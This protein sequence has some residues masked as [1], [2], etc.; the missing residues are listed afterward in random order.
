MWWL[1]TEGDWQKLK[2]FYLTGKQTVNGKKKLPMKIEIRL[3]DKHPTKLQLRKI[4]KYIV[5]V[6]K[7]YHDAY[8]NLLLRLYSS[9][10]FSNIFHLR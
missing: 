4:Q 10:R 1:K 6:I 9:K 7:K 3:E 5:N 2:G 8:K